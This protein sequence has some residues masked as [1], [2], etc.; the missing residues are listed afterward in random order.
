MV[1]NVVLHRL[2]IGHI[3]EILNMALEMQADHVELAN[4]QYYA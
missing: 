2:N 3:E 4:T 1:L